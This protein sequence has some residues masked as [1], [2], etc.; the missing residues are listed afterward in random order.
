MYIA[1]E[2]KDTAVL[3][4]TYDNLSNVCLQKKKTIE[5]LENE[6]RDYEYYEVQAKC[7]GQNCRQISVGLTTTRTQVYRTQMHLMNKNALQKVSRAAIMLLLEE[8]A[9][10]LTLV[11]ILVEEVVVLLGVIGLG[12][13]LKKYGAHG[14]YETDKILENQYKI[15]LEDLDNLNNLRD[16][17]TSELEHALSEIDE[18]MVKLNR[19]NSRI[20]FVEKQIDK[21]YDLD[22]QS[23][24]DLKK[25][26]IMVR[27]MKRVNKSV[28][29]QLSEMSVRNIEVEP[30]IKQYLSEKN[31]ELPPVSS[32][33]MNQVKLNNNLSTDVTSIGSNASMKRFELIK[34][35]TYDRVRLNIK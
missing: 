6:I 3:E 13:V 21:S 20:Q 14:V 29:D 28:L 27:M 9:E 11:T 16:I 8:S 23:A 4:E 10:E 18:Q 2:Q 15:K 34:M 26:D 35:L 22:N 19:A 5:N 32:L 17:K 33:I 1:D 30:T 12:A 7:E 25:R 24:I 31:L